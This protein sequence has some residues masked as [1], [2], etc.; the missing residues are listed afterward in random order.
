[1]LQKLLLDGRTLAARHAATAH[2]AVCDCK[3]WS[4][5]LGLKEH[6]GKT[7]V[8]A[9]KDQRQAM[10]A[11]GT[12]DESMKED[13]EVFGVTFALKKRT[14]AVPS[15]KRRIQNGKERLGRIARL[16][17]A[18]FEKIPLVK[19]FVVPMVRF[20]WVWRLPNARDMVGVNK[21]LSGCDA[22]RYGSVASKDLL[23]TMR[24][25]AADVLFMARMS[26]LMAAARLFPR[27]NAAMGLPL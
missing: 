24:G 14:H 23:R 21:L 8:C 13:I 17:L 12:A 1:M 4:H 7:L 9:S 19:A 26:N 16:P 18:S 11:L 6:P 5:D 27:G 10:A 15:E 20:V 3:S 25:H 22:R 2:Q